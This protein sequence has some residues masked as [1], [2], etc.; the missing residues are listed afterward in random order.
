MKK[1]LNTLYITTK[2][3]YLH[4]EGM[5]FI[6]EKEGKKVFQAPVSTIEDIVCFGFKPITPALMA[7]CAE[8]NIGISYLSTTGRFLARV[9]GPQ[10]GNVLLRK[11]QYNIADNEK[12][13]LIIARNVVAAKIT[14]YRKIL[15]R[16]VRNYKEDSGLNIVT[17]AID[18]MNKMMRLIK[19]V[20]NL[21]SLRGFEGD[22]SS[23]YFSCFKHLVT[24]QKEDFPFEK[25]TKRPPLDNVNALLS[26]LYVILANDIRSAIE[27]TGLDSQVGFLHRIRSGRPS[28]ALDIMEEFR[29]YLA[30]RVVLN[31]I[32]LCQVKKNDFEKRET[33]EVRLS[34]NARKTVISTYQ[35]RK[36][37]TIEHPFLKEKTT[38]GM[39]PH[40][41]AILMARYI[42][43]DIENYPPFYIK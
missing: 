17:R 5:T 1:H 26:F 9:Y 33:G 34:E 22:F 25:R 43:G 12:D 27:T 32:N 24:S 20:A 6:V 3:V 31:V 8:N 14:N 39:L 21:N 41:Q 13:S 35:N 30:D 37:K 28:L 10:K 42:R 36:Q 19:N 40:I 4:K 23:M 29:G 11:K 2:D 16:H 18:E 15:Q 38:I 7:F